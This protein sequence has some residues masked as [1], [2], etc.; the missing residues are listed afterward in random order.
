MSGTSDYRGGGG[1]GGEFCVR[2]LAIECTVK[3]LIQDAL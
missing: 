3:S 2:D 1:G